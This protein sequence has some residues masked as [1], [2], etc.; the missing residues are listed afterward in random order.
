MEQLSFQLSDAHV[1][2]M[3]ARLRTVASE[4]VLVA[5]D[6]WVEA[7]QSMGEAMWNLVESRQLRLRGEDV[8]LRED[9]RELQQRES[10]STE[11]A[12][13]LNETIRRDLRGT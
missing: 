13:R 1:V 12:R 11:A 2:E 3:S 4:E 9:T 5:F 6:D 7:F 8:P 10:A